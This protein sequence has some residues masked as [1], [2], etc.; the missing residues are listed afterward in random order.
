[1]SGHLKQS[2]GHFANYAAFVSR[3]WKTAKKSS[4][5]LTGLWHMEGQIFCT[6]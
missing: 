2:A 6:L 1:L 3:I 4:I 5:Q